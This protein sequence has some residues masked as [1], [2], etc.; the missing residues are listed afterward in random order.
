MEILDFQ[1]TPFVMNCY[2]LREDGEAVLID[3]GEDAP[4]LHAALEGH[5]LTLIIN[6]HGHID[7][8]GGNAA[9]IEATGAPLALHEAD[10]PLLES[11]NQQG[12]MFGVHCDPSPKPDRFLKEGDRIPIGSSEIE[13][14]H[15]P[16]HSPGH[17]VL[18]GD[19][20]AIVGDVLFFRIDRP[21]GSPG[22]QPGT[23]AGF[24]PHQAPEP[25]G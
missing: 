24:D 23:I 14:L 4:Q 17:I 9:L 7:H 2:I 11:M 3:P 8:C 6:T 12:M 21:H 25:A 10:L 18:V 5:A 20:F 16:G 13:V 1:L 19:G 22:R 15:A